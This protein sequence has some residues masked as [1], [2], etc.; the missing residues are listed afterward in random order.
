MAWD[1]SI[2]LGKPARGHEDSPFSVPGV[3]PIYSHFKKLPCCAGEISFV[4]LNDINGELFPC[5]RDA[6][7]RPGSR[8]PFGSAKGPKPI[9]T[10]PG[11]IRVG[12]RKPGRAGQL[13]L[14]KQGQPKDES[15]LPGDRTAGLEQW[16]G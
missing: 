4:F 9:D 13:A 3:Q 7:V 16:E 11:H 1:S 6:G 2:S 8:G 12:G 10:P 5:A 14:L 15:V